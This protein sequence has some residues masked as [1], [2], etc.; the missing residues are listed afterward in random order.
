MK[1]N[2]GLLRLN[3]L[4]LRVGCGRTFQR[5]AV[6][7]VR[8]GLDD[9]R[10]D[11]GVEIL[12]VEFAVNLHANRIAGV[13]VACWSLAGQSRLRDLP[14]VDLLSGAKRSLGGNGSTVGLGGDG[15]D[16]PL[17]GMEGQYRLDGLNRRG[18]EQQ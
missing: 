14:E 17:S 12:A 2:G 6:T 8:K 3:S 5:E 9:F 16:L 13:G 1:V 10:D 18:T 7:V 4:V 15:I 11:V